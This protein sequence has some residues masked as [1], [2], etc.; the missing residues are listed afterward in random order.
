MA[1]IASRIPTVYRTRYL[2]RDG[3]DR[4]R[5]IRFDNATAASGFTSPITFS[6][7]APDSGD[8]ILVVVVAVDDDTIDVSGITYGG[9]AL[10]LQTRNGRVEV[11]YLVAPPIGSNTVSVS[12][13]SNENASIVALSYSHVD[14]STPFGTAVSGSDETGTATSLSVNVSSAGRQLVIDGIAVNG[15]P[16]LTAGAG[17]TERGEVNAGGSGGIMAGAS[18]EAGAATTTMSWSWTGGQRCW[19]VG[20][21]LRPA[22]SSVS[23]GNAETGQAWTATRAAGSGQII[24]GEAARTGG[25]DDYAGMYVECNRANVELSQ[26]IIVRGDATNRMSGG[27]VLRWIDTSNFLI[28]AF[29]DSAPAQFYF[30]K[31]EANAFSLFG[32]TAALYSD[33][34]LYRLRVTAIGDQLEAF[35]DGVSVLTFTLTATESEFITP[36]THGIFFGNGAVDDRHDNFLVRPV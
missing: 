36:T 19:M 35:I 26:D 1:P 30:G 23:L 32:Q 8:R 15:N 27:F 4:Y 25:A 3:F 14:Q 34:T 11:W 22:V 9:Q 24:S 17:Q 6:H 21:P 2:V 13:S 7:T 18:E 33:D 12:L 29:N 5:E 10:T 31:L 16:A 28:A 20:V